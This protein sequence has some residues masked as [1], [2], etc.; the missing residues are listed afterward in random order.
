VVESFYT[1]LNEVLSNDINLV[2]FSTTVKQDNSQFENYKATHPKFETISDFYYRKFKGLVRS[3]LSE[4]VFR[5]EAYIKNKFKDYPLA[6]HS[7]DRAWLDFSDN[8]PIFSINE[9]EMMIRIS[10]HSISGKTNDKAQ[11]DIA[12]LMFFYDL[13]ANSLDK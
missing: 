1:N 12:R 2:R 11:K 3:S 7:D 9:A 6:W 10:D 5:R 13:V 8:K 4:Y